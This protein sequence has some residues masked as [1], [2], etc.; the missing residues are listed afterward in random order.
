MYKISIPKPCFAD[1]NEMTPNQ[2]GKHCN[3]CAKTVVDFTAMTDEAVHQ[4][5]ITHYEK[6][7]C[8][9]F[10]NTQLQR[11][12]IT[13]PQNIFRI[14]LPFWKKFLVAFL[15]AFGSTFFA[16]DTV[17][18]GNKFTQGNTIKTTDKKL[19]L[20]KKKHRKKSKKEKNLVWLMEST[21]SGFTVTI[22]KK[23][24]DNSIFKDSQTVKNKKTNSTT[25]QINSTSSLPEK[26]PPQTP[27]PQKTEFIIPTAIAVKKSIFAKKK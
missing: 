20:K 12:S 1:W 11:I 2:Q 10:K 18:A 21:I 17:V 8:G 13:L 24:L 23:E 22:P 15:I 6:Q 3:A 9:H 7:I 27:Q 5:F 14:Q 16:I 25:T 4:Y 19:T 26:Q